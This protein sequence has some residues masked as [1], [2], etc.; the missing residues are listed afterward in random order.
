MPRRRADRALSGAALRRARSSIFPSRSDETGHARDSA[1]TGARM[2]PESF[3]AGALSDIIRHLNDQS[4]NYALAGGWAFSALVEPRATTDIDLVI[5]IENPSV[6]TIAQLFTS[7]FES[8]VPHP[9]PMTFKGQTIWRLVGI[10]QECEVSDLG[11]REGVLIDLARRITE[12]RGEGLASP[13]A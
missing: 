7:T 11:L 10:R 4:T 12:Q 8:V 2:A 1:V 9:A 13:S 3:L 6:S 5:L